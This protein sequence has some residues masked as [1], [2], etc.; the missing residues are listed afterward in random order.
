MQT[1]SWEN[2]M[3]SLQRELRTDGSPRWLQTGLEPDPFSGM[4]TAVSLRLHHPK[5]ANLD[6]GDGMS[7][8]CSAIRGEITANPSLNEG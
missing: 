3:G 8:A 6:L 4:E 7:Q 1:A 2:Y 5:G